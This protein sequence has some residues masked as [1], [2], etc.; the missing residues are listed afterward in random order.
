MYINIDVRETP[1]I[2]KFH[3]MWSGQGLYMVH[4]YKTN[5]SKVGRLYLRGWIGAYINVVLRWII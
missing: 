2:S 1:F 5:S 4:K 3:K